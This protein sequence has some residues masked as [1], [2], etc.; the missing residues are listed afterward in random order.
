[1]TQEA[2]MP[3][4][5]F[6]LHAEGECRTGARF[7]AHSRAV[8]VRCEDAEAY[9]SEFERRC[10]DPEPLFSAEPGALQ[11]KVVELELHY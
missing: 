1:V 2:E 8:F 9:I 4:P 6:Q 3:R 11:T 7:K 10:H 5:V